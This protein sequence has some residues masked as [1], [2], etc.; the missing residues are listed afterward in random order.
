[1]LT[2]KEILDKLTRALPESGITLEEIP[3]YSV[4]RVP[5]GF[6]RKAA[7]VLRDASD[8]CMDSLMCLS[9][10]D[11][12][13]EFEVVYHLHSMKLL[14]KITLHCSVPKDDASIDSVCDIWPAADWHERE[15]FDMYGVV[16]NGHPDPRRILCPDDWEGHP[17]RKDYKAPTEFHGIP[18]TAQLPNGLTS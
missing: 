2:A 5:R 18:L 13:Q 3:P 14:H 15:I 6:I 4:L 12:P 7:V 1:M 17:L 11:R 16:F 10:V 9:G 8:L